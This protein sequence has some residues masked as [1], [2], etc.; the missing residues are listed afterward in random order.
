MFLL[1]SSSNNNG[2]SNT[3]FHI[4]INYNNTEP[5][6][7][8]QLGNCFSRSRFL[9]LWHF[10]QKFFFSQQVLW[11]HCPHEE[12]RNTFVCHGK[13]ISSL[14]HISQMKPLAEQRRHSF[15]WSSQDFIRVSSFFCISRFLVC[16]KSAMDQ[17]SG[18]AVMYDSR[19]FNISCSLERN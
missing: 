9:S 14:E 1:T 4:T 11:K 8:S 13:K 19:V 18:S 15:V 6:L 17:V 12:H 3:N 16:T 7:L 2:Y 5:E 10:R